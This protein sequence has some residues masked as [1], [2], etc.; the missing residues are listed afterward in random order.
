MDNP[1]D[2]HR[3]MSHLIGV[4]P[5]YAVASFNPSLQQRSNATYSTSQ[6]HDAAKTSL[7]HRGNGTGPD[8]DA[9]WEKVWRAAMW[10]Q[11]ADAK[12][13]Y[14]ELTV[15]PTARIHKG[16]KEADMKDSIP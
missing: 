14:H 12:T 13:F 16:K 15:S 6:I 5:G 10:A 11:Y 1:S 9:G 2:T 4:Y 7:I 3:H 8:A